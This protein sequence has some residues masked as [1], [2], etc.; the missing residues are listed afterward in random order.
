MYEDLM[1]CIEWEAVVRM[2]GKKGL[3]V[4]ANRERERLIVKRDGAF[5]SRHL[6]KLSTES[7]QL[8]LVASSY[9]D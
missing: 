4:R 5:R 3:R 6:A 8:R 2:S 1:R 9:P 7:D